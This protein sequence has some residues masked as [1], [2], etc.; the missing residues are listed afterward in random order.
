[1]QSQAYDVIVVGAGPAGLIA[2]GKAAIDGARVAVI[3]K[4]EKPARKLRITGKGRCNITNNKNYSDFF[5]EITPNPKFLSK[6]FGSF[7]SQDIITLL[8]KQGVKTIVERGQRVFPKSGKAWDVA[9]AIERWAIKQGVEI[10]LK[11]KVTQIIQKGNKVSEVAVVN[12]D[13]KRIMYAAKSVVIAT[14][15]KSYPATGSTG[16]GYQLAQELG[17][18]ITHLRPSLTGLETHPRIPKAK[19]LTLK[20]VETFLVSN[21]NVIA[22]EFGEVELTEYGLDG[23]SILK[24]S[25]KAIDEFTSGNEVKICLDL[26][27]ALDEVK[28]DKRIL[29]DINQPGYNSCEKLIRGLV[30]QQLVEYITSKMGTNSK[31]HASQLTAAERKKLIKTLKELTFTMTGYRGWSEAIVTAGGISQEEIDSNTMQSKKVKGLFFSG[32]IIDVSGNTGGYNLQI[33]FSTG[34]LAGKSAANYARSAT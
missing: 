8:E 21:N 17:H 34:W 14:G 24:L 10:I 23:P 15:G 13:K 1:M 11:S 32:E 26:K 5:R 28:L 16:D 22:K 3:E 9:N 29:R 30:P 6:A 25:L 33:A 4:M 20:N 12:A 18:T 27:P 7:F 31:M 19:G 2:A